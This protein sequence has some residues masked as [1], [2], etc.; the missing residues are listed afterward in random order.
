M[1]YLQLSISGTSVYI[2]SLLSASLSLS[3]VSKFE[4]AEIEQSDDRPAK[5]VIQFRSFLDTYFAVTT[6]NVL[7]STK[8]TEQIKRAVCRT[9]QPIY[10]V[11][12]NTTNNF[13]TSMVY[14]PL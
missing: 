3:Y 13:T 7:N 11:V 8:V 5:K 10:I 12:P 1:H 4:R 9:Y 14:R 2:C 6:S